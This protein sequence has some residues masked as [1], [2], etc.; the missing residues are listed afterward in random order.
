METARSGRPVEGVE[1]WRVM[2]GTPVGTTTVI[3]PQAERKSAVIIMGT[4]TLSID[5]IFLDSLTHVGAI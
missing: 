2:G 4:K 5:F 1:A 3:D